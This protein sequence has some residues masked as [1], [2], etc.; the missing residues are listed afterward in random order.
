MNN[1]DLEIV[2]ATSLFARL[3]RDAANKILGWSSPKAFE[4]GTVLFTQGSPANSFYVVLEGWVKVYRTSSAGQETVVAVFH[5]GE[6]FA[7]A[8][9]FLGG[10]YPASAETVTAARL[11]R[12]G[13]DVLRRAIREDPE[14]AFSMLASTSAHLK[15]LIEQIEQIKRLNAKQRLADF[16]INLS[17]DRKGVST[18]SLPFEKAL[19]ANR[20][21][22]KPE[23][24]SRAF[25]QLRPHGVAVERDRV[26][27]HD[28]GQLIA[29]VETTDDDLGE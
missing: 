14:I 8:S 13:G 24:L 12:I 29:L 1:D 19:I 23:S 5:R 9:I 21:G 27:I 4:K 15:A 11:V 28:I 20:L 16:L 22:M 10:S 17:G 3:Q 26:H 18:L 25:L 2:C 7:E 6:T